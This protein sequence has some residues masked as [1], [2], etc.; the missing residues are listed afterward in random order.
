MK[1]TVKQLKQ[2]KIWLDK[3][4]SLEK[5]INDIETSVYN[6]RYWHRVWG[7]G[8]ELSPLA[9]R[10]ISSRNKKIDKIVNNIDESEIYIEAYEQLTD[11]S[12]DC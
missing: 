8:F 11:C 1:V 10:M 4:S 9:E 12:W 3:M 7:G 6:R 5:E 2:V